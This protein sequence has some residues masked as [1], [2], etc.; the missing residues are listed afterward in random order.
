[1]TSW[2]ARKVGREREFFERVPAVLADWVAYAARRRGV[3][4]AAAREA[5]AAVELYRDEMLDTVDDP[6]AWGP[7]KAFGMAALRAGV[8]LSDPSAVEAFVERHNDGLAA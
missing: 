3:P 5:V 1:M 6:R 8:D 4:P 2:L 7:A